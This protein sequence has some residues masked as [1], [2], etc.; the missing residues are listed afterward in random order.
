MYEEK[1]KSEMWL[2]KT[3]T[4]LLYHDETTLILMLDL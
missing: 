4:R 1:F 2:E 3:E